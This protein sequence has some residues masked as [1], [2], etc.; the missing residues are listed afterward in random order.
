MSL[1]VGEKKIIVGDIINE[2]VGILEKKV[3]VA[4]NLFDEKAKLFRNKLKKKINKEK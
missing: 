2:K 4:C 3:E 1:G